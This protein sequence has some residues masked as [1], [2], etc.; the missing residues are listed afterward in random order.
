MYIIKHGDIIGRLY[1]D[2]AI[3]KNEK[4]KIPEYRIIEPG[5]IIKLKGLDFIVIDPQPA[6]FS[7][8]NLRRTQSISDKD[9]AYILFKTGVRPGMNILEI[10]IGIGTMSYAILNIL[11]NGSLTSIDINIEN[12]KNSEKNVNE[13]IDTGNW[14]IING[15]IKKVQ[16]EK[17]DAVIVDIPD[18]WNYMNLISESLKPGKYV[19]FYLP[20]FDQLEKT[21][22]SMEEN[23]IYH[24]ESLELIKRNIIVRENATRP[25]NKMIGHTAYISI[26][27]KK[28]IYS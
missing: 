13:L 3:I 9:I 16:G 23:G 11:G 27:I 8:F 20:N 7:Y 17:Y 28:S 10:G 15:D 21:V 26:G 22:I 18:P 5:D 6:Y 2:F 25:D 12:I 24:E 4:I 19:S 14:R 1:S